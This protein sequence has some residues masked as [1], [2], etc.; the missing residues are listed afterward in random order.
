MSI[1]ELI[2]WTPSS[3]QNLPPPASL[4]TARKPE[5]TMET[6]VERF[7]DNN[8]SGSDTQELTQTVQLADLQNSQE[9][10]P[11]DTNTKVQKGETLTHE[12]LR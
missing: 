6:P 1:I 5:L 8:T 3:Q 2:G 11:T 7:M 4:D 10:E 9:N 12:T